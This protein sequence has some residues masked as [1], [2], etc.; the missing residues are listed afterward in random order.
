MK[1]REDNTKE[2]N[3]RATA[4]VKHE[5]LRPPLAAT[6]GMRFMMEAAEIG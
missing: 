4:E 1:I 2:V 3:G 6:S 5:K